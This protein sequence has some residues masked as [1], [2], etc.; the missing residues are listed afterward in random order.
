MDIEDEEGR[1]ENNLYISFPEN[2]ATRG[3]ILSCFVENTR[4]LVLALDLR[5]LKDI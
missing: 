3:K 2:R 4:G 5:Y 1:V